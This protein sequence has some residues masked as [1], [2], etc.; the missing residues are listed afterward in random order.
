MK[1]IIF[2][3]E[4]PPRTIHGTSI[5]NG[6]NISILRDYFSISVV[7]EF[8]DLK[9]HRSFS[10]HKI[11]SFSKSLLIFIKALFIKRYHYYYGVA[12]FSRSGVLKNLVLVF[13]FKLFNNKG[14]IYL[15][16]HRS[17]FLRFYINPI[18]KFLFAFLNKY[19]TTF[20]VLSKKQVEEFAGL[21]IT[22]TKF[23]YNTIE[24]PE[25]CELLLEKVNCEEL[26]KVT[27]IG[28]YLKDKGVFDL[29]EAIKQYNLNNKKK[30][31]LNCYGN[32]TNDEVKNEILDIA[33]NNPYIN[34][35]NSIYGNEKFE[36]LKSSHLI[37]LPS[38]NEGLPLVLIEALCLGIPI[39]ITKVGYIPEV[40]PDDYPFFC[41][42][43]KHSSIVECIKI[44]N[45]TK[46]IL[47]L[48][49]SLC[50]IYTEKFSIRN[51]QVNL[52]RIFSEC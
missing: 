48:R 4:L 10:F 16:V 41:Y 29:L 9:F 42:P 17:D 6:L 40:L 37:V 38:Y 1:R 5:S 47:G 18:N 32:F 3:G 49:N 34:I 14:H 19:V 20:I 15:H 36:I 2:F 45:E 23:L 46:D 33:K 26:I 30:A 35:N 43:G 7:E 21:G 22:Q 28:N 8:S 27:Y 51:H 12:Y 25:G 31:I 13:F 24:I 44:F 52:L 50:K 11:F 39:I